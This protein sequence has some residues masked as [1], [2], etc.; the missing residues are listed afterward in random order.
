MRAD[1]YARRVN[2]YLLLS[3]EHHEISDSWKPDL[4]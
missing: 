4:T 1:G 3:G 2:S